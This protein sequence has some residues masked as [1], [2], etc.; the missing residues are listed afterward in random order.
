ML[1]GASLLCVDAH[2]TRTG[3]VCQLTTGG[4]EVY[5]RSHLFRPVQ[6]DPHIF[7]RCWNSWDQLSCRHST[8]STLN[9]CLEMILLAISPHSFFPDEA[10]GI[11]YP[12]PGGIYGTEA[13][14]LKPIGLQV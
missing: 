6:S 10:A 13:F 4:G 2:C 14:E 1:P 3:E 8:N 5:H 11:D 12:G 9:K 7:S